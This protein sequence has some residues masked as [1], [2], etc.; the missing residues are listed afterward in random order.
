[1]DELLKMLMVLNPE[2]VEEPRKVDISKAKEQ[3]TQKSIDDAA[4][5]IKR[6]Y[7]ALVKAGF[8]E[9]QAFELI[10]V[11]LSVMRVSR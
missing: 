5:H 10:K 3:I 9:S 4:I 1:M 2:S 7:D 8:D 11:Q 6:M